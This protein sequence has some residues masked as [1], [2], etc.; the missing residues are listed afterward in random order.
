MIEFGS[1][2]HFLNEYFVNNIK[3]EAFINKNVFLYA[4]GRHAINSILKQ[5][6]SK[7]KWQRLWIPEYF[8]YTVVDAIRK[9]GI[10]IT[11]YP[12]FPLADDDF[13]IKQIPFRKGDVLLRMNF[14]G[15][16]SWRCNNH[17]SVPVI[18]DHSHDLFSDWALNSNADFCFA[19]LRKTIPIPEGGIS[20]SPKSYK[21]N[22][23][24]SSINN[25][26]I[27]FMKLSAMLLKKSYL[28][29]NIN[30]SKKLFRQLFIE[31]EAQLDNQEDLSGISLISLNLLKSFDS[32]SFYSRKKNNW[33]FLIEI[34]QPRFEI[35]KPEIIE[36]S[37]PFSLVLKFNN[38]STRDY[39]RSE[40]LLKNV[41]PAILWEIPTDH[42]EKIIN[43]GNT[44]LSIHC[45]G[46]YSI[47]K[48]EQ[49]AQ[50]LK[51]I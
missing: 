13:L 21:I 45:D 27:S 49:M 24:P 31:S 23:Y 47:N 16:R 38:K 6:M 37:T 34:L 46:R 3:S 14:W 8:C 26:L 20:W 35:Y 32:E 7:H 42:S 33:N 22:T 51:S 29:N 1:D 19:S 2:F 40:L 15:L 30:A 17:I 9:T 11:F 36:S 39:F 5:G 10:D 43:I 28:E 4:N 18:E 41:Y 50:I 48:I 44:T 25:D 12:D